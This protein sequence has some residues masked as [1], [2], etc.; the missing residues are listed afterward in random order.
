MHLQLVFRPASASASKSIASLS[1]STVTTATATSDR[2]E[3]ESIEVF[4]KHVLKLDP[5]FPLPP[6]LRCGKRL[7][8]EG[9]TEP[10]LLIISDD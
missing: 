10:K 7:Q 8:I 6:F 5:D 3:T 1:L 9:E 4:R 2:R